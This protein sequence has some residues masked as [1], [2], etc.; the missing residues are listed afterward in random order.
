MKRRLWNHLYSSSPILQPFSLTLLP[1]TFFLNEYCHVTAF[2]FN[3]HSLREKCQ[4][5][6]LFLVRIFL[7]SARV[8]MF[9][10]CLCDFGDDLKYSF[11]YFHL[12]CSKMPKWQV[13]RSKGFLGIVRKKDK[14][15]LLKY[16]IVTL[17]LFCCYVVQMCGQMKIFLMLD[18][19]WSFY[20]SKQGFETQIKIIEYN[21]AVFCCLKHVSG[22]YLSLFVLPLLIIINKML[23]KRSCW[24]SQG[25]N[26]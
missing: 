12:Y 11:T 5:T 9:T 7:Y 4:N 16:N 10:P 14:A 22:N 17:A 13:L 23:T 26:Y 25:S 24:N 15:I 19:L 21:A 20:V 6:E 3:I 1:F 2:Y 8:K 18:F